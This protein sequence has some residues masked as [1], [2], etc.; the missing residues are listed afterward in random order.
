MFPLYNGGD[1]VIGY[2]IDVGVLSN[3][4]EANYLMPIFECLKP[5][6]FILPGTTLPLEFVF[7]PMEAKRYSVS[8]CATM[9]EC[10]DVNNRSSSGMTTQTKQWRRQVIGPNFGIHEIMQYFKKVGEN[11]AINGDPALHTLVERCQRSSSNRIHG[12]NPLRNSCTPAYKSQGVSWVD[13]VRLVI[14]YHTKS[15]RVV[16]YYAGCRIFCWEGSRAA[17][18]VF[19]VVY[20]ALGWHSNISIHWRN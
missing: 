15:K 10:V 19:F 9:N 6:G 5:A 11:P 1:T 2:E 3:L 13:V 14:C 12:P 7:S 16:L 8:T 20:L 18:L 4:T 17:N